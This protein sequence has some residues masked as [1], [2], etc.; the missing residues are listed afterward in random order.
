MAPPT[1]TTSN[2]APMPRFGLTASATA[3]STG[4]M[5]LQDFEFIDHLSHFN[6]ERVP[7][8]VV[9]AKGGGAFGY[10]EVAHPEVVEFCCAKMFSDVGKRTPVAAR[11][12]V[13]TGD[14][15]AADTRVLHGGRQLGSRLQQ[16]AGLLHPRSCSL[17][18]F[19]S[20][21]EAATSLASS[22]RQHRL[23]LLVAAHADVALVRPRYS[24]WLMDT[25]VTR[26][27]M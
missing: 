21:A 17:P 7:Q 22:R 15:G 20:L 5:L 19:D 8:R 23:G 18:E 12:S 6:R 25:A 16:R 9:Y 27:G 24:G 10:F 26:S 11:F 1:C 13:L 2:G 14:S 3:G 4:P